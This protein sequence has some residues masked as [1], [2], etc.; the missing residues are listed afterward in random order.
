MTKGTDDSCIGDSKDVWSEAV[1]AL[2]D[3]VFIVT[4]DRKISDA[5]QSAIKLLEKEDGGIV[6]KCCHSIVHDKDEPIDNCPVS[7]MFKT[8]KRETRVMEEQGRW[9][10][11]VADPIFDS[12]G[13]IKS[14]IHIMKDITDQV[15]CRNELEKNEK[16]LNTIVATSFC[17]YSI[18][19]GNT[20][21]FAN[22]TLVSMLG[23]DTLEEFLTVPLTKHI[24]PSDIDNVISFAEKEK[25]S[26]N[27][28]CTL[29]SRV[30]C[31]SGEI[32]IFKA[33]RKK[34]EYDG[35]PGVLTTVIDITR[36]REIENLKKKVHKYKAEALIGKVAGKMAHDFNNIMGIVMGVSQLLI[37][38]NLPPDMKHYVQAIKDTCMR[39]KDVT[40]N[41]MF[42]AKDQEPKLAIFNLRHLIDTEIMSLKETLDDTDVNVNLS[43]DVDSVIG[44]VHL[45]SCAVSQLMKNAIQATAKTTD[46]SIYIEAKKENG[47]VRITITDNGCGIPVAHHDDIFEPSFTLKGSQD[48][49]QCYTENI[50]GSGYGLANVKKCVDLHKGEITFR[51]DLYKGSTFTIEFPDIEVAPDNM[52]F[53][54][55]NDFASATGKTILVVEDEIHFADVLCKTLSNSRNNVDHVTDGKT[56]LEYIASRKYDAVSLDFML[57]DMNGIEIYKKI[58]EIDPHVPIIFVSGNFEFLESMIDLKRKDP[59]VGHLAKPFDNLEYVSAMNNWMLK[60]QH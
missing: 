50:K 60:T 58:R 34:I 12:D 28:S 24:H 14:A 52:H 33:E 9:Y 51:S 26:G 44:D 4:T 3:V 27:S 30:V 22:Q 40:R 16:M 53:D 23:Y 37:A 39:G 56:A 18:T 10:E 54:N 42:F 59:R 7:R 19:K 20:I 38:E 15:A 1:N 31:K 25:A 32:K 45:I 41:L 11:V 21:Q 49:L 43:E 17:G 36:E 29:E 57:P 2:D 47:K 6:G 46:P 48:H 5:N 8:R 13:S 55:L 35:A